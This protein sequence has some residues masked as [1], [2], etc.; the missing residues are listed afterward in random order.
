M[1]VTVCE[2]PHDPPAAEKTWAALC[3]HVRDEGTDLLVL[4]E[5]AFLEPVWEKKEFD[6]SRWAALERTATTWLARLPELQCA[7][8]VGSV[9]VT[10]AGN[11]L[12]QGFLWSAGSGFIPLRSKRYL[13]NEPGGWEARWFTKGS[14]E[15][16]TFSAGA[17]KFGL[18]IC[19]ELWAFETFGPY[20]RAGVQAVISPRATA[21]ATTERWIALAKTVAVR[22]GAFSL[23][24]N[25]RHNDGSCGGVGW[26]ID[27][28]GNELVRTSASSPVATL[29][30]DLTASSVAKSSYPR[31]VF[32]QA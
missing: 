22:T 27:P 30:L 23:S 3:A 17:L 6:Q 16:P 9:P 15:F 32:A 7:H 26:I 11:P 24:S 25:R 5:F 8:V 28:E 2:T 29:D 14:E 12:N 19:T 20:A 21:A 4:P 18:N 13:P 10:T 1:R 31:Y